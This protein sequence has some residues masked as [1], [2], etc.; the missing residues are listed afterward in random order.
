MGEHDQIHAREVGRK[1]WEHTVRLP[2]MLAVAQAIQARGNAAEID[3]DEEKCAERIERVLEMVASGAGSRG[4]LQRKLAAEEEKLMAMKAR[5][6]A[7]SSTPAMPTT[8]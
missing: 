8:M 5:M 4:L 3:D 1:K 6:R 2:F 7:L